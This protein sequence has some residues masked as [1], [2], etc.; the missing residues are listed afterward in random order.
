MDVL[1]KELDTFEEVYNDWKNNKIT[2]AQEQV[3][4]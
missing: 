4:F 2:A 3:D 1:K